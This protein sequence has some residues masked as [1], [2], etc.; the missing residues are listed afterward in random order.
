MTAAPPPSL[1]AAVARKSADLAP[2]Q[3]L[4]DKVGQGTDGCSVRRISPAGGN[5]MRVRRASDG[6]I[7][8]I[9]FDGIGE[10]DSQAIIDHCGASVGTVETWYCF[11][12]HGHYRQTTPALQ[13]EIYDGV[14]VRKANGKP[15]IWFDGTTYL[16]QDTVQ[17]GNDKREA[18]TFANYFGAVVQEEGAG[19]PNGLFGPAG[20]LGDSV[21]IYAAFSNSIIYYDSGGTGANERSSTAK[22]VGWTGNQHI[23]TC[24]STAT[25]S[26]I[27]AND[28][29]L[30]TEPY[31][32]V[33]RTIG[34]Q[35][36]I[37]EYVSNR[38]TGY[39]QEICHWAQD[40]SAE[41]A[42]IEADANAFYNIF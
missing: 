23:F 4:F 12:T 29:Q 38:F 17:S 25:D 5:C 35:H 34:R 2:P 22:P 7:A 16:T 13:P 24:Y 30:K 21:G 41:L 28:V 18:I 26:F 20:T 11:G 6:A 9:G 19:L 10:L 33:S 31:T 27:R 39:I 40:Q 3:Y 42:T 1:L 15:A 37:G 14:A 8:E 36:R 32:G